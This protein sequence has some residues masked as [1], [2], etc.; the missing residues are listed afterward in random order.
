MLSFIKKLLTKKTKVKKYNS[1]L[2]YKLEFMKYNNI[3]ELLFSPIGK[4]TLLNV[5]TDNCD[6]LLIN[7]YNRN[8]NNIL[9]A[10]SIYKYFNN[11]SDLIIFID[12]TI[13]IL[14]QVENINSYTKSDLEELYNTFITLKG[15]KHD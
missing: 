4:I 7:L 12:R 9:M 11:Y 3:Q 1:E 13:K 6:S 10:I 2:I 15:I 8:F 5:Y 14:E